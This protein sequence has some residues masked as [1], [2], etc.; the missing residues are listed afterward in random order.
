[1]LF[2]VHMPTTLVG[3]PAREI[4]SLAG[5]LSL[6]HLLCATVLILGISI[7]VQVLRALYLVTIYQCW[8]ISRIYSLILEP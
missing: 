2:K 6:Q 7:V 4:P 3:Q 8:K 5:L 1:M